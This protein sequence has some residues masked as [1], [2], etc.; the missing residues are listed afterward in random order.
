[1]SKFFRLIAGGALLVCLH[2][3]SAANTVSATHSNGAPIV[4]R[5]VLIHALN[6]YLDVRGDLC[7][8]KFNWPIDVSPQDV[9]DHT[10][11][12]VQMPVLEKFNLVIPQAATVR[13]TIDDVEQQVNVNQY[14]LTAIGRL[15]YLNRSSQ[16]TLANGDVE[17][18]KH[19]LCGGRVQL[20]QLVRW[21]APV[22]SGEVW[23]TTLHYTYTF[24]P[25]WWAQAPEVQAVFPVF[26]ILIQ[27]Q[28][29]LQLEQR[30]KWNGKRWEAITAI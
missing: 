20:D 14:S 11:D 25:V 28:K 24:A 18:Q 30:F 5:K 7:L 8:G 16:V 19:D 17:Q 3:A 21:D 1:M 15:Y 13:R 10:R 29:K 2:A 12:A 9:L 4:D 6:Q 26:P 27:G 23:E 22:K